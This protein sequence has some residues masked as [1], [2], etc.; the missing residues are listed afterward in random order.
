MLSANR[1]VTLRLTVYEIFAVKW[2]K[3]VSERPKM[4]H[5]SGAPF[6]TTPHLVTPKD[7]ATKR[8]EDLSG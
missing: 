1:H 5:P 2:Q 7:I 8:G 4:V 6:L 3:S